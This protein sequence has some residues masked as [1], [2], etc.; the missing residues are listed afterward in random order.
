MKKK[1]INNNNFKPI[2]EIES[3]ISDGPGIYCI[4]IVNESLLPTPFKQHL[5]Q[6]NHNIL[7]I[8]T[9]SQSLKKR[10]LN[11][12]LRA[13]GHGTFFRSIG[14]LL[15]YRPQVGSLIDKANK[16]NFKF[17]KTDEQEIINWINS[18]LIFNYIEIN[19]DYESVESQLIKVHKPLIN[20]AKNP[21]AIKELSTLR[22]ECVIIANS[23]I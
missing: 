9:A 18:N 5:I 6:R 13:K 2:D 14:A 19:T 21:F 16:R 11:Q 8:G 23:T 12:E 4:R 10:F 3:L 1:L 20:I 15:G 22:N 17:S 7:Y